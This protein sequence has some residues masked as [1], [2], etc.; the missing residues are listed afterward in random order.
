MKYNS[1]IRQIEKKSAA[2]NGDIVIEV[3]IGSDE[4]FDNDYAIYRARKKLGLI[5]PNEKPK[6]IFVVFPETEEL[7]DDMTVE[8]AKEILKSAG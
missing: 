2:S 3:N 7:Y 4:D 6:Q 5:S 8:Q 1:R